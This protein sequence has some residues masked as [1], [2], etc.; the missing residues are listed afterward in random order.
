MRDAPRGLRED[1]N[2]RALVMGAR[3][4]G[5]RILVGIEVFVRVDPDELADHEDRAVGSL[6]GFA[7]DDLS[8]VSSDQALALGGHVAGH[9]ELYAITFG[10]ADQRVSDPSDAGS[11]VDD[12]LAVRERSGALA[13]L[14][15]RE[16][17]AVFDGPT[18]VAPFRSRVHLEP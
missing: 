7:V 8:S 14:D 17:G 18:G 16:R 9:H 1:L 4:G 15:H 5:V 2:R 13:I 12:P 6:A 3:V 11:G 10:R